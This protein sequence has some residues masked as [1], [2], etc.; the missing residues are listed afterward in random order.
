MNQRKN[1]CVLVMPTD[2]CNM[3]CVY[4]YHTPHYNSHTNEVMSIET[5]EQ[6]F[7][8]T[9]PYYEHVDFLWHG[10]E[11]LLAGIDFY[12]KAVELQK[13]YSLNRCVVTNK[14]QTNCTLAT[15]ELVKFL[16]DSGFDFGT[17][18]DGITNEKTRGRSN[19][20][21][22]GINT[23]RNLGK[24]CNCILVVSSLNV[25]KLI[26]N[27]EFFKSKGISFKYNN[28][29]DT[30]KD[31]LGERLS[32]SLDEYVN[33]Q[34]EFFDYWLFDT[35][36]KI[37]VT[38]FFVYIEYLLFKRKIVGKYNSCLGKWLGVRSN[39]DLVQCNRY[40]RSHYGNI[41]DVDKISDAFTSDGFKYI[42]EKAVRRREKCQKLC[43]I[44]GF[45]QGGCVVEASHELGIETLNNFS[46]LE[47][48]LMYDYI[49]KRIE[50]ILVNYNEIQDQINPTL[51]NCINQ[52]L[53]KSSS[54][55]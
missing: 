18:F 7:S 37:R 34:K 29:I 4:C 40:N 14:I 48:Q 19:D 53:E 10:G 17:S 55:C 42:L 1:I 11:P 35:D 15:E 8:K 54:E 22:A 21:L 38:S 31:Q 27:Y 13:K 44:Y 50:H 25:H 12:R 51:R 33:A 49:K 26:E 5:L 9:I 6:I 47:T 3:R 36:C 41:Y 23:I 52:Y 20:I 39:G 24:R 16:I 43:S 45:C 30:T 46:C 2:G 32:L 28:Y